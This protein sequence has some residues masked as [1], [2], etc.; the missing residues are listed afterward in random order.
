MLLQDCYVTLEIDENASIKEVKQA[1]RDLVSIWH[2]DKYMHNPRLHKKAEE[3]IKGIN[4]AYETLQLYYSTTDKRDYTDE[5]YLIIP[6]PRCGVKNRIR[7]NYVDYHV[8]CGKCGSTLFDSSKSEQR[9]SWEERIL[10]SDESCIGTIGANGKCNVC[11]K[12][13]GWKEPSAGYF[14]EREFDADIDKVKGFKDRFSPKKYFA[15]NTGSDATIVFPNECFICSS[16]T[17]KRYTISKTQLTGYYI[18]YFKYR[19]SKIEVPVCT[20]H[21]RSLISAKLGFYISFIALFIAFELPVLLHF[22]ILLLFPI[23]LFWYWSINQN[24]MIN[25]ISHKSDYISEFIFSSK[26]RNYF[27]KLVNMSGF[28]EISHPEHWFERIIKGTIIFLIIGAL[29]FGN[30]LNFIKKL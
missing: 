21:Y 23:L 20:K 24:L 10:C 5:N 2:P 15:K 4:L 3:K 22:I 25:K 7:N 8:K 12:P 30:V 19:T 14:Y 27:S 28:Q 16:E 1:Y 18:V 6:C 26:R 29:W 13:F 11:G 17:N 9:D